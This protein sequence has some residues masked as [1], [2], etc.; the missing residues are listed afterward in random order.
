MSK[1]G[2]FPIQIPENVN[3][4]ITPL[5]IK[6]KGPKGELERPLFPEIKI[7]KED[8]ILKI[9]MTSNS[10]KAQE[11]HGLVRTL[12]KNMIEGVVSGFEKRLKMVG[13]GYKAQITEGKLVLNVGFSH[14]VFLE[15]PQGIEIKVEKNTNIIVSGI[16]KERVGMIAAKIRE[17]KKPEPYKGKGI[18]YE[19]ERIRRKAG[20]ALK[21]GTSGT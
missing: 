4:E 20:K 6:A 1:V 15:V 5:K 11:L 8:S 12:I 21:A 2:K 19:G 3:L 16:D 17:I 9:E 13:V 7:L 10:R 18:M 14:Q